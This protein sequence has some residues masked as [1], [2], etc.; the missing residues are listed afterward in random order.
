MRQLQ[1]NF[2]NGQKTIIFQQF[3]LGHYSNFAT[4]D[5]SRLKWYLNNVFL[6]NSSRNILRSSI[7]VIGK[8][9]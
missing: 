6:K 9:Y 2:Y 8:S 4:V 1:I 3:K 5:K 7:Q